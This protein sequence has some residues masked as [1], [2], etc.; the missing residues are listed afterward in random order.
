MRSILNKGLNGKTLPEHVLTKHSCVTNKLFRNTR[1]SCAALRI[2]VLV[3]SFV[4]LGQALHI[5][6][7]A[8]VT[9]LRIV[10]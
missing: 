8:K 2:P 6:P 10:Y 4:K 5:G 1:S 9:T 7:K 3:A